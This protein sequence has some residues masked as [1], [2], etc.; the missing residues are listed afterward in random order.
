MSVGYATSLSTETSGCSTCPQTTPTPAVL[1]PTPFSIP[2]WVWLIIAILI[3]L[4]ILYIRQERS[5]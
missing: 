2:W 3:I 1:P 4:M 5:K